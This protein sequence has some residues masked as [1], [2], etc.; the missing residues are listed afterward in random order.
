[1]RNSSES[2]FAR[3]SYE[4][5][6]NSLTRNSYEFSKSSCACSK[7]SCAYNRRDSNNNSMTVIKMQ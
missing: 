7:S 4:A 5:S 6:K 3:R 2:S 1:M